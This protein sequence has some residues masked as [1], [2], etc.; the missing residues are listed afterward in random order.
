MEGESNGMEGNQSRCQAG[1]GYFGSPATDGL[2]SLCYKEVLKKKQQPP[3]GSLKIPSPQRITPPCE[4]RTSPAPQPPQSKLDAEGEGSVDDKPTTS[5]GTVEAA[6]PVPGTS[7]GNSSGSDSKKKNRCQLCRKKVGLTG[8]ECRCGGLFCS[9]HRYSDKHDCT[10]DY[11]Q[12]GAEEIRKNN[13][14]VVGEK[15]HKI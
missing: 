2:C 3:T 15:I 11:R 13:P 6:D 7:T 8:F 14:V 10:F 9:V 1:C 12:L 5:V 4:T